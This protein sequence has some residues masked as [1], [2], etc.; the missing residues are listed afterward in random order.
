MEKL[1]FGTAGIPLSSFPQDT[2]GGIKRVAEL[3]LGCMEMEFV[4]GIY[5]KKAATA[6]NVMDT[7]LKEKV[8]LSVHAPYYINLNAHEEYKLR[9]SK[10]MILDS[11]RMA[12]LSGALDVVFHAGF[13][14]GDPPQLTYDN[15]RRS[16]EEI[17]EHLEDEGVRVTLRPELSGKPSQFGSLE[18]ILTLSAELEG[19]A[20]CIDFAHCH[21][22][23]GAFNSYDEFTSVLEKV[24]EKLGIEALHKLHLHISGI[25]YGQKGERKHLTLNDSDFNYRELLKA[26]VNHGVAGLVICESPNLEEDAILLKTAYDEIRSNR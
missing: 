22:R 2:P 4:R 18:E 15:I 23:S 21:A 24:R 5:L 1:L 3:G 13:Y 6:E 26:L 10:R 16:I 20:P 19:V 25:E 12:F 11:A 8:F 9:A 14:L 17:L 7:A